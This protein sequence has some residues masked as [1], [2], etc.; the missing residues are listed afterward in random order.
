MNSLKAEEEGQEKYQS[1]LPFLSLTLIISIPILMMVLKCFNI[2]FIPPPTRGSR[3]DRILGKWTCLE[4]V[5]W[6][7]CH[8]CCLET[9]S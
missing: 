3:K 1:I 7:N 9:G 8:L 5:L 4:M 2:P 6:S